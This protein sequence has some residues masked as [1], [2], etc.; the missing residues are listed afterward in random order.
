MK[1]LIELGWFGELEEASM[2]AQYRPCQRCGTRT[3]KQALFLVAKKKVC[4][5]CGAALI[6]E[7][8]KGNLTGSS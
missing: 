3:D 7:T 2:S 6:R 4:A 5:I 1:G 8:H